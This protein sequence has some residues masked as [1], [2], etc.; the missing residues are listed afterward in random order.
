MRLGSRSVDRLPFRMGAR[1]VPRTELLNCENSAS[2]PS[3]IDKVGRVEV[4]FQPLGGFTETRPSLGFSGHAPTRSQ[5]NPDSSQSTPGGT[6]S[7]RVRK[8]PFIAITKAS[9]ESADHHNP[10]EELFSR[11]CCYSVL[12]TQMTIQQFGTWYLFADDNGAMV[13]VAPFWHPS[14]PCRANLQEGNPH[15]VEGYENGEQHS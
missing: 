2:L 3:A 13:N 7:A 4:D 11:Q 6:Q 14:C 1:W 10:T 12:G 15:S 8:G 9:L 5:V